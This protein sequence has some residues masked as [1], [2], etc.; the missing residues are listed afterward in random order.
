MCLWTGVGENGKIKTN[1]GLPSQFMTYRG[2]LSCTSNHDRGF[3]FGVLSDHT[4]HTLV[5]ESRPGDTRG[6]QNGKC[7]A[8]SVVVWVPFAFP[9]ML[10]TICILE[11]I[12]SC[13]MHS[14][15]SFYLYWVGNTEWITNYLDQNPV[16]SATLVYM[17]FSL[18]FVLSL[19]SLYIFSY[20]GAVLILL[21]EIKFYL[22]PLI[23]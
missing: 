14:V 7:S 2:P 3:F 1:L 10:L 4:W 5:F 21:W 17:Y 16:I 11:S 6:K 13:S 15:Q 18:Y 12:D 20:F 8:G 19:E 9:N 23:F 22:F